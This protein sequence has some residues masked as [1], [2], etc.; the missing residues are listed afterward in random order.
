MEIKYTLIILLFMVS[1]SLLSAQTTSIQFNHLTTM[2]GLSQ[3]S[4]I[5]IIQDQDGILW[6]GT[7]DGLNQYDGTGFKVFRND[8]SDGESISNNDI[9]DLEVDADGDLWVAT[10]NGLNLYDSKRMKFRRFK[11]IPG[12]SATLSNNTVW[13]VVHLNNNRILAGSS[14]GLNIIEKSTGKIIQVF[15]DLTDHTSLSDNHVTEVFQDSHGTIWVGTAQGLNKVINVSE[16]GS[17]TFKRYKR[18]GQVQVITEDSFGSLWF[19]TKKNGLFRIDADDKILNFS[20]SG[21]RRILDNDVRALASDDKGSLWVGTYEGVSV[22]DPF[23]GILN[24][25]HD[26]LKP[27]SLSKNTIKSIYKDRNG[28]IWIGA[29]YGGIN[30][31]NEA[32]NNFRNYKELANGKGLS[33]NVVSSIVED[34]D[35]IYF[36]TEGGGVSVY[37]TKNAL[38]SEFPIEHGPFPGNNIKSLHID[39]DK[40][41]LWIGT[42]NSGVFIWDLDHQKFNLTLTTEAGLSNNSIYDIQPFDNDLF[43]IGTFGGGLSLYNRQKSVIATLRHEPNNPMS[44][45]D[46]QVRTILIDSEKNL[47][48]GTQNGLSLLSFDTYKKKEY[49][50]RNFFYD[51][52]SRSGED[53][54]AIF[55]DSRGVIWVGTKET[56]LHYFKEGAFIHEDLSGP[57]KNTSNT[58]HS[59]L[60]DDTGILWISSNSGIIRYNPLLEDIKIF[61]QSDGLVSNEYNNNSSLKSRNGIIYFGGPDG[62]TSFVPSEIKSSQYTPSVILTGL[63]VFNNY[64]FP[65]DSTKI[66]DEN[67]SQTAEIELEYDEAIF[68]IEFA[69][70]SYI[71]PDKNRY[72]YRLI[73]LD[74]K[75]KFTSTNEASYTIQQAGSYLFEVKGCNSDGAWNDNATVL[76]VIV[77]PA[78]WRTWWAFLLYSLAIAVA[79]YFLFQIIQSRAEL[80]HDLALEHKENEQ[81][82]RLNQMKLQFFT[83]ISHEFRTPLTLILGP[84]QQIIDEYR[85][86]SRLFKQLTVIHQNAHQLLKLINQ[87]MEFRKIEN[88]Q[89]RLKAAEGN[90]VKFVKEIF[91]SFKPYAQSGD[92]DYQF[93][94]RQNRI[95]VFYDRDKMERVIYNLISN[96]FKYTPKKRNITLDVW[97][98]S[99]TVKIKVSDKG[100]GMK[101][102]QVDRIFDRFYQ[103]N[104]ES[105]NQE[106]AKGTGIGLAL[107]KGIIDLHKGTITAESQ[108][109]QGSSFTISLHLGCAHLDQDQIIKN[110]RDSE[111]LSVYTQQ[112]SVTSESNPPEKE[113]VTSGSHIKKT[114]LVVEDNEQVRKFVISILDNPDYDLKEA[115]N[116]K[117]GWQKA[118]TEAPDLIISDVMMPEMDGIELCSHIKSDI[119][120]SHIPIILLTARTSLIFKYEG[121]ESGADDYINKPFNVRE[122]QLKVRNLLAVMDKLKE[123]FKANEAI[124]PSE[125]TISSVDEELFRKAIDIVDKN[126]S[127]EFLDVL[128]FC[129][130]LGVSRTML[131]T[132]IK[133]WVN[134]TPNEFIQSMRMK[135]AAQ[136][137]EQGKMNVSQVCYKVGYK[138][139]KYFS[140]IFQR[141]HLMTPTQYAR[142]F[143]IS[144]LED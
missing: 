74:E 99:D 43:W 83:N 98:E 106:T 85:G 25:Q 9:L 69:L 16:D 6:F 123:K 97:Q 120:T 24:L 38:F 95:M 52:Q 87:L 86:S 128:F 35:K 102:D 91:L 138:N 36:G 121:L 14:N 108:Y 144:H 33:Y 55:E 21:N 51:H 53:V 72:S 141:H 94:A 80:K 71:N 130:E 61:E 34:R 116:G 60:E 131:F 50:M 19:G 142:K 46:D 114:I 62:V 81:E 90:I 79:L 124:V 100:I 65:G 92:Y 8:I 129:E 5:T 32:N 13:S 125:I 136:L 20:K 37:D 78:P 15:S 47:W 135:R 4:V 88:N 22:I 143:Q 104:E 64:I 96:A 63:K 105:P 39:P 101:A 110:F 58:I 132:K 23:G 118:R 140:K 3:S 109:G 103:I 93:N 28:S 40:R 137:L 2:Q 42:F 117:E 48:V 59:I 7:R 1:V 113:N 115:A 31:W 68:T 27:R 77:H 67:I 26:P 119:K 126:I 122:L 76:R 44:L 82:K 127:N 66:L 10:Y 57:Y 49:V 107:T 17:Y 11:N 70:P 45:C 89:S 73:G 18:K 12:D 30:S 133:A 75:W 54:L 56:G 111:D 84:L 134:M 41:E 112:V 29:Y 139:P